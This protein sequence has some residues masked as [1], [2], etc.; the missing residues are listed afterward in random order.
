MTAATRVHMKRTREVGALLLTIYAG[1]GLAAQQNTRPFEADI[2]AQLWTAERP[3]IGSAAVTA[4][5]SLDP[6]AHSATE[7][8][9]IVGLEQCRDR[10]R[11]G[12]GEGARIGLMVGAGVGLV[13]MLLTK[14]GDE[15]DYWPEYT[16][17][18]GAV[19]GMLIGAIYGARN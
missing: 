3:P 7:S 2:P 18:P 4:R 14:G 19:L 11:I 17:L 1:S 16:V 12:A 10:W 15:D 9:F 13:A 8:R 6:V 5:D